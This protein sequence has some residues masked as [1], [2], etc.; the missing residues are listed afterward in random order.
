MEIKLFDAI[1]R[2]LSLEL[3]YS[4]TM[5]D[6]LDQII[7]L[8]RP[9]GEDLYETEYYMNNRWLEIREDEHF[10]E[11][12]L[13]MFREGNEYMV[14]ID[15]NISTGTWEKMDDSNTIILQFGAKNELYDLAFMNKDFFILQ[16]HGDQKRKGQRKYFI[17]GRESLVRGLEWRDVMEL[18][19]NRYRSNS[20]FIIL[21]TV[22]AVI[23]IIIIAW[24]I[25]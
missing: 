7:P 16:K 15:G 13:H 20:Q 5:D 19:F 10:H 14:S 1:S 4:E 6:Y 3:P 17:L 11:Q 21:V 9:W 8:V 2:S 25:F 22:V 23:A 24:S 18:L 12:V